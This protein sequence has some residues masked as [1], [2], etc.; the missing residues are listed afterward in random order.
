MKLRPEQVK[1]VKTSSKGTTL[2][3][4]GPGS[5]KTE[6]VAH[7]YAWLVEHG[8]L[9]KDIIV[10]TYSVKAT[11]EMTKRIMKVA[12][13]VSE[14]N[15]CTI[16]AYAYRLLPEHKDVVQDWRVR[17]AIQSVS[18]MPWG[19]AVNLINIAKANLVNTPEKFLVWLAS[20]RN[21]NEMPE[22]RMTSLWDCWRAVSK[23]CKNRN[24]IMF[25]DMLVNALDVKV[26][27][28][29]HF[30]VDEGQDL[31]PTATKLIVSNAKSL[32]IVGD[33]DQALYQFVGADPVDS[34][35][36]LG[37]ARGRSKLMPV[38]VMRLCA[39]ARSGR[40]IVNAANA[41]IINNT[42]RGETAPMVSERRTDGVVSVTMAD[43]EAGEAKTAANF[44]H[45]QMIEN[46]CTA[47]DAMVIART[48]I[49]LM[50]TA[51]E[52]GALRIPFHLANGQSFTDRRHVKLLCAMVQFTYDQ[53]DNL[54]R[55]FCNVAS[56]NMRDREGK[57]SPTR[58]LGNT[59]IT[60]C[61]MK[62]NLWLGFVN[63]KKYTIGEIDLDEFTTVLMAKSVNADALVEFIRVMC[64]ERYLNFT[65]DGDGVED[66]VVDDLRR[67]Q[68]IARGL[69]PVQFISEINK[70]N[71]TSKKKKGVLLTSIHRAK[72]LERKI[73]ACIGWADGIL[74]HSRSVNIEHERCA[75]YVALTRARDAVMVVGPRTLNGVEVKH[76]F[77][78]ELS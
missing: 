8:V 41:L 65:N 49:Y 29:K 42:S 53:N 77:I 3:F 56:I 58:Y 66:Y 12:G 11:E 78:S 57:Y 9:P 16:H 51:L 15:I 67:L 71:E 45:Q 14:R 61:A 28:K 4:A 39:N 24:E 69:T 35:G 37:L 5:G 40:R 13:A 6:V 20:T 21:I 26:R 72:G 23:L 19:E 33:A 44:V 1:A 25:S 31:V 68:G 64:L 38:K 62:G 43:D 59:F 70:L 2:V 34:S 55:Q 74:P 18:E 52:L 30:I 22:E 7:R 75:A 17:D 47:K 10:V 60:T 63:K 50:R 76:T 36:I 73:V 27:R 32:F 46:K 54:F 48:N